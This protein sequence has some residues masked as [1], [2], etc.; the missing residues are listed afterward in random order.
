M[1]HEERKY[2]VLLNSERNCSCQAAGI[3]DKSPST[4]SLELSQTAHSGSTTLSSYQLS[5]I[6]TVSVSNN[7]QLQLTSTLGLLFRC[8]LSLSR[9]SSFHLG[10]MISFIAL[11]LHICQPQLFLLLGTP[12][13]FFHLQLRIRFSLTVLIPKT[14]NVGARERILQDEREF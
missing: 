6:T 8:S 11:S 7:L 10:L 9:F 4:S 1:P 13:I 12:L 14:L 2:R 5:R 3:H